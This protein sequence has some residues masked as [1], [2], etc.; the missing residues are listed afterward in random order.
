MTVNLWTKHFMRISVANLL[1]FIS[2]YM[3]L[4][5]LPMELAEQ[6]GLKSE[7]TGLMFLFFKNGLY[8]KNARI[9]LST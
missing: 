8:K 9:K 1:L 5:V 3:L 4:P 7:Q 2:L 6:I